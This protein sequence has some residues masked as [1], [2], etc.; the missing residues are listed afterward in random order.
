MHW[1]RFHTREVPKYSRACYC[2]RKMQEEPACRRSSTL[3]ISSQTSNSPRRHSIGKKKKR[4]VFRLTFLR[5]PVFIRDVKRLYQQSVDHSER[6]G[7]RERRRKPRENLHCCSK[8]G[9]RQLRLNRLTKLP[10]F[11]AL[12]TIQENLGICT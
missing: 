12:S 5:L 4:S 1:V 9:L 7:C 2:N 10:Q 8:E 3:T 11:D 6:E